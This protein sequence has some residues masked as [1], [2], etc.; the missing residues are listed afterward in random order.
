M[1]EAFKIVYDLLKW[2]SKIS[3]FTYHEVNIIVY[4]I[5]IPVIFIYMIERILK[6]NYLKIGFVVLILLTIIIVPD[7]SIF[8]TALFNKSVDFLNWFSIIG[9]NYIQ[10]SVVICVIVPLIIMGLLMYLKRRKA[11]SKFKNLN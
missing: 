3:G 6:T 7:F 4:F 5:I 10:A 2:I 8:S 1:N 9:L 11:N